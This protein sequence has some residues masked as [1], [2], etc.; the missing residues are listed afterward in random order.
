MKFSKRLSRSFAMVALGGVLWGTLAQADTRENISCGEVFSEFQGATE[1]SDL[2][3]EPRGYNRLTRIAAQELEGLRTFQ[4]DGLMGSQHFGVHTA[5]LKGAPVF[6][7]GY[8]YPSP[9][10]TELAG[11]AEANWAYYFSILGIG[12]RFHGVTSVNGINTFVVA[13]ISGIN[14]K[15][16]NPQRASSYSVELR[17][18]WER[19]IRRVVAVLNEKGIAA[20]D[21]QFLLSVDGSAHLIDTEL[22]EVSSSAATHNDLE[23]R[24]VL[25]RLF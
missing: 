6:L 25:S 4:S 11:M 15:S 5:T 20:H 13:K 17:K 22:F 10:Y 8:S 14:S 24:Y 16:L 19:A 9:I 3:R 1:V 18:T 21:L 2:M 7:K 23:L 12:P